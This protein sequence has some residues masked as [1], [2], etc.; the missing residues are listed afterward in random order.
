MEIFEE[1]RHRKSK[2][3]RKSS[4]FSR[5]MNSLDDG[6]GT[7]QM[8]LLPLEALKKGE[9]FRQDT[10]T[11]SPALLRSPRFSKESNNS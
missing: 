1:R 5:R 8:P 9:L 3:K 2:G 7:Q 4:R 6:D 10:D 11:R